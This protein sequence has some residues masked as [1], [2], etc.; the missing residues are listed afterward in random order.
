MYYNPLAVSTSNFVI[1]QQSLVVDFFS[2][3]SKLKFPEPFQTFFIEVIYL[4][5]KVR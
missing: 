4:K 3:V 5:K 1:F 2:V